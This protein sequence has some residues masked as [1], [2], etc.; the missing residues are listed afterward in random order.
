MS[1]KLSPRGQRTRERLLVAAKELLVEG[2]GE[3][4]HADVAERARLSAGASYRYFPSKSQLVAAV[5]E[6]FYDALEAEAYLPTFEEEA[7][8]WWS[9]EQIRIERLV[10]AFF[11]DP[12]GPLI[13]RGLAQ[14]AEVARTQRRRLDKQT[15]GAARNVARGQ[16][17]GLVDAELDPRTA[18]A[19]L[20]G[21]IYHAISVRLSDAEPDREV[22]CRELKSFMARVLAIREVTRGC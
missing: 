2:D 11:D 16:A 18:G 15:Y 9:R 22:L 10:D 4:S 14:D 13:A 19:L 3:L 6:A 7:D 1:V 17:L 12:L 5:V 8:D 21:G 20:M